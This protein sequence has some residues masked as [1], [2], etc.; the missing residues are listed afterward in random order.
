MPVRLVTKLTQNA[1]TLLVPKLRISFT[2]IPNWRHISRDL[3]DRACALGA[4]SLLG[5]LSITRDLTIFF[6]QFFGLWNYEFQ[7]S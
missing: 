6:Q 5:Y 1:S 7:T 2:S 4:A 3:G